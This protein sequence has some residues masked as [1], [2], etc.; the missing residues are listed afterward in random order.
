MSEPVLDLQIIFADGAEE[1]ETCCATEIE[2]LIRGALERAVVGEARP[3]NELCVI[4]GD[5]KMLHNLNLQYLEI[6]EPT[7]VLAFEYS[8][9]P[10]VKVEGD[11][12][13]SLERVREQASPN[14]VSFENE[15]A[16]VVVHGFLHLCG[17]D[18]D[19]DA[20]LKAMMERGEH[21]IAPGSGG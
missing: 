15:L 16:R 9:D 10:T 19:N 17:Y 11:I 1:F 7:D 4:L 12:F 14:G 3:E 21:Y 8:E 6:D 2:L 13:V 18:H 20:E 5:N